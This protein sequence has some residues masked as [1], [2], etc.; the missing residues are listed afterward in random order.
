MPR[1]R[2]EQ[3]QRRKEV[4]QELFAPVP[5]ERP[6]NRK[7][8]IGNSVLWAAAIITSALVGAPTVLTLVLLP[9]LA[10]TALLV[11]GSKQC[12]A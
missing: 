11:N 3:A 10:T 7:H 5:V 12:R 2:V 9:G 4:G 1:A 8:V 6:M